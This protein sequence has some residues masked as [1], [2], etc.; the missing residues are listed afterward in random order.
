MKL[1]ND[2][3]EFISSLNESG[4]NY[5]LVGGYA[6][7]YHGY[8]RNTGDMDIW[9]ESTRTNGEKVV[10]ALRAFGFGTMKIT[11]EDFMEPNQ[12]LQLGIS[13]VRIDIL[14]TI[15]GVDFEQA[16]KARVLH[17]QDDIRIPIINLEALRQNKK[18]SGRLKDL[19]DLQELPE[20]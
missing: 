15:D 2:F 7:I 12:I 4:A 10:A 5:L 14:T 13:P 20:N 16:F 17:T 8:P 6:V 11:P 9:V 19:L 18:V 1:S 3:L